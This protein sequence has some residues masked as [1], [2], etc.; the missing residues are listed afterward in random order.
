M[1]QNSASIDGG[2]AAPRVEEL[3]RVVLRP[4]ATPLPLGFLAL[5][6]GSVLLSALQLQWVATSNGPQVATVLLVFVAPVEGV[7]AIIAFLIR[8]V[9][10]ATLLGLLAGSWATT[11]L[12]LKDGTPG[13]RS[14]TL[15]ILAIA[16]A[17]ALLVPVTTAWWSKPAA[18]L[19]G[20]VAAARFALTGVYEL[21]APATWQTVTGVV[22][23]VLVA[24][25]LYGSL[26]LA[27]EDAHHHAVLPISRRNTSRYAMSGDLGHQLRGLPTEAGVRQES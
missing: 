17:V 12:L 5:A 15:G 4:L 26:A 2:P 6:I 11:G 21:G 7:T 23:V 14:S 27:L 10:M 1:A 25:A 13:A 24:T 16:V 3:T 18:A 19:I 9:V 20:V 22:G 8:D